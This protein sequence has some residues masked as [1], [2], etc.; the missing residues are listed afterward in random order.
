MKGRRFIAGRG[1]VAAW[2][3]VARAPQR[4][5]ITVVMLGAGAP[6]GGDG[7]LSAQRRVWAYV[8]DISNQTKL[9]KNS[10]LRVLNQF[11]RQLWNSRKAGRIILYGVR[12]LD[13]LDVRHEQGLAAAARFEHDRCDASRGCLTGDVRSRSTV[14]VHRVVAHTA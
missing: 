4:S 12:E 3:L 10:R 7:Y 14:E 6:Q 11:P 8:A 2:P 1:I 9:M 5:D 13:V